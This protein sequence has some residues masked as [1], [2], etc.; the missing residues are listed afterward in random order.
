MEHYRIPEDKIEVVHNSIDVD[1]YEKEA[2]DNMYTYLKVMKSQGWRVVSNIGRLTLQKGLPNLLEAFQKVLERQPKTLL[3][4]V[5]SGEMYEELLVLSANLGVS[6][7][8]LFIDFQR[9]K[10]LRDAFTISDLFVM[11]S[12]SE[13]FGIVPLE[14]IAFGTPVL[15]SKQSGVAEVI[16]NCLKVDFWDIDEMANQIA[17]VVSN[18]VLRDELHAQSYVEF[19]RMSWQESAHKMK[20]LYEIQVGAAT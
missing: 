2:G 15:V 16:R 9:G 14:A 11:P 20:H 12:V 4:I 17:S 1:S 19:E 3:L 7:N 6:S 13:P 8:V 5:G 18:D 10:A